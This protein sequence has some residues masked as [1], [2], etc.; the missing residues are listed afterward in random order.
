MKILQIYD[1][2]PEALT[3]CIA[4]VKRYADR[5]DAEYVAVT[6]GWS[7]EGSPEAWSNLV[8]VQYGAKYK[9]LLY[10][11]WDYYL[12]DNFDVGGE[13]PLFGAMVDSMFWTG[14]NN[15]IF[16]EWKD[17]MELYSSRVSTAHHERARLYKIMK[18]NP[19]TE[20]RIDP[21]TYEHLF[22]SSKVCRS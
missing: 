8:R 6:E 4:S 11:D 3:D 18:P 13:T 7:G 21:S 16:T 12:Y 20:N 5:V 14:R 9:N 1:H 10:V 22:Y 15:T 2:I 17:T 19:I